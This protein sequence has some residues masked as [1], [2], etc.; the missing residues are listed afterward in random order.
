[1]SGSSTQP[2]CFVI[3]MDRSHVRRAHITQAFEKQGLV[4]ERIAGIDGSALPEAELNKVYDEEHCIKLIGRGLRKGEI[5][6]TLSHIATWRAILE[7]DLEGAFIFEDDADFN[8]KAPFKQALALEGFKP[9]EPAIILFSPKSEEL[10][11][12]ID[13][14][15]NNAKVFNS[16]RTAL[17]CAYY[18]NRK[19][20]K[21]LLTY[22]DKLHHINDWWATMRRRKVVTTYLAQT[23]DGEAWV[24][25]LPEEINPS[26]LNCDPWRGSG[27]A[28]IGE[29]VQRAFYTYIYFRKRLKALE[30]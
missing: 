2:K 10:A 3:N 9:D 8:P 28:S 1:M 29:K 6:C 7:Q 18:V 27:K 14:N 30:K 26:N 4:F 11:D 12:P 5:G 23:N 13:V 20:A 15:V 16:K 25:P 19:A 21:N 17:A 24:T 22:F